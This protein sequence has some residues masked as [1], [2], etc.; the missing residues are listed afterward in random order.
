M[1]NTSPPPAT[2]PG[3]SKP[4]F[5]MGAVI[6]GRRS[7][8]EVYE[9]DLSIARTFATQGSAQQIKISGN[10]FFI[11]QAPDVG[12]AYVMFE[13]VQD[14]T[15]PL[16]KPA[17]YVGP[18]TI[19]NVPFANIRVANTVQAGKK[20]RIIYGTDIDFSPSLS[21]NITLGGAVNATPYGYQ[22]GASYKSIT[23]LAA[24]V[25]DAIFSP[26][27]NVNGAILWRAEMYCAL[28][29]TNRFGLLAKTSAPT[30]LVDGD[31]FASGV[32]NGAG[33]IVPAKLDIP[34]F[35]AAGK[36]AYF[37]SEGLETTYIYRSALYTLL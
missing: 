25:P 8:F 26:G 9:V 14:E 23:A 21:G 12:N 27:A 30:T 29:A 2:F 24:L 5:D 32:S 18:G 6:D 28:G 19:F 7:Q 11:D 37:I 1:N 17:I 15:N 31:L 3:I 36:G 34:V 20:L 22:Y 4:S 35:V 33:F 16:V 13:G 10:R